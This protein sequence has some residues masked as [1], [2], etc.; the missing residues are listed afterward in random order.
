MCGICVEV[1]KTC[2][3][4]FEPSPN[5]CQVAPGW[6]RAVVQRKEGLAERIGAGLFSWPQVGKSEVNG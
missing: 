5:V 2:L 4:I 6:V 1:G 3:E